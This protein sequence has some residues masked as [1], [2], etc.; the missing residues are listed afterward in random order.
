[1]TDEKINE[2]EF[3]EELKNHDFKSVKGVVTCEILN[4]TPQDWK[5]TI[6]GGGVKFLY[7]NGET[8]TDGPRRINVYTGHGETFYSND[9]SL[10][11]IEVLAAITVESPYIDGGSTNLTHSIRRDSPNDCLVGVEVKLAPKGKVSKKM[12]ESG[13]FEELFELA[14]TNVGNG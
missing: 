5:T 6:V 8:Y 2:T 11:C 4:R 10:C 14:P 9:R 1:M 7:N 12:I 13:K 3:K